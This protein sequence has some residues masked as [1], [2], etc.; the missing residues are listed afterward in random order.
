LRK[1]F[2]SFTIQVIETVDGISVEFA[3]LPGSYHDIDGMKNMFFNLPE[4]SIIYGDSAFTDYNF[5]EVCLEAENIKMMISRKNNSK[6]KHQPWQE[7]LIS[8]SRKRIET[9]FSQ[10]SVMFPKRIH[11]V[12]V[13]GFFLKVVLFIFV[14]TL[15]EKLL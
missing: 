15:N 1:Y 5:E 14:F 7:Y 6:R 13:E 11:A 9:T 12:T 8:V 2:Y 10:I 4:G 3:I